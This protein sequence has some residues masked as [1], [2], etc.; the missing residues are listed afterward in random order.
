MRMIPDKSN[1][2]RWLASVPAKRGIAP[3]G[4]ACCMALSL[5][6]CGGSTSATS[7]NLLQ[8][9]AAENPWGAIATAIGGS[10]VSVTSILSDPTADPHSYSASAS[11]AAAVATA[12]VVLQNGLGYDDFMNQLLGTGSTKSRIV[13]TA[14]TVM[15]VTEAN[16]NP[17]LWYAVEEVPKMARAI[18]HAFSKADPTH[19]SDYEHNAALFVQSLSPLISSIHAIAAQRHGTPVAQTERVAQYLLQ[20]SGLRIASPTGFATSIENGSEPNAADSQ[21]MNSVITKSEI[22]VLV[23]NLQASS[24]TTQTVRSTARSH[25]IPVVGVTET[26]VPAHLSYA[27]WQGAQIQQLVHALKVTT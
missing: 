13:V 11:S 7:A 19:K 14:S 18:T 16:A 6:A 21:L 24:S 25:G 17:H 12:S 5:C 9:V 3:L 27:S 20:E 2:K 22:A 10:H 1:S 4:V 26:V 23:Y 8:V 15:G